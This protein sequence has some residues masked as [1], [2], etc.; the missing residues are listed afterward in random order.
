MTPHI[1]YK[2]NYSRGVFQEKGLLPI[3]S[4]YMVKVLGDKTLGYDE[5]ETFQLPEGF[6][7]CKDNGDVNFESASE[8]GLDDFFD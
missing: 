1:P 4:K 2:K 7:P 8:T 6:D 3:W 5:S